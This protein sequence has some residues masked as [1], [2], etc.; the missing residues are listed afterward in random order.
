MVFG[1]N[2]AMFHSA[3]A[4]GILTSDSHSI[5]GAGAPAPTAAGLQA[6]HAGASEVE[7]EELVAAALTAAQ[8][9]QVTTCVGSSNLTQNM[10]KIAG[11]SVRQQ[12][13]H[14]PLAG[15]SLGYSLCQELPLQITRGSRSSVTD[16]GDLLLQN[17]SWLQGDGGTAPVNVC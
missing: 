16:S 6:E 2:S 9:F 1:L 12:Q 10:R 13:A 15:R 5:I 11:S 3:P 17:S 4:G 14:D 8:Q 7:P